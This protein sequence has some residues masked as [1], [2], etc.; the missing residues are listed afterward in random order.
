M[1]HHAPVKDS[2][3]AQSLKDADQRLLNMLAGLN[4]IGSAINRIGTEENNHIDSA[5]HLIAKTAVKVLP[6]ATALV[7]P[8]DQGRR[9]FIP[10]ALVAEVERGDPA[11]VDPTILDAMGNLAISQRRLILSYNEDDLAERVNPIACFPLIVA[12]QTLGT[13]SICLNIQRRFSQVEL[14]MLENFVY[15]AAMAFYQVR[16]VT[17]VQQDLARKEDEVSRLRRAGLLISSRLRIEETL[18]AILQM[19]LEVINAHYGIFRLVDKD[20]KNLVTRAVAEEHPARPLIETLPIDT[21]SVMGWVAIYRQA[22]MIS[23][24]QAEPWSHIYYPLD[25][26]L[27]MRSELAVPLIGANGR[28]E[29]V[30]NLESPVPEAFTEQDSHLLQALAT[31]AVIAIQ[32][33]RLLDA[34]QEVAQI[35]LYQPIQTVLDRLVELACDL[36]NASTSA[37]WILNGEELVLQSANQVSQHS[38]R[39]PLHNSLTGQAILERRPIIVDG[40]RDDPRFN[41]PDLAREQNWTR[42]LIVPLLDSDNPEPVGAFSVY[43]AGSDPGRFAESEWDKKVLTCL[44]YYAALAVHNA[45]RQEALRSAQE[46]RAVAETF[47]AVGDIAANLLHH[48]NNKVGTIP[49]RIQGIQDKCMPAVLAD[50]YLANNLKEIERSAAEAMETVRENLAH[51]RPIHLA[52]VA[53]SACIYAAVDSANLPAR[54]KI[55]L[56]ALDDLPVVMAGQTGLTLVFANLIENAVDAM[57]GEGVVTLTGTKGDGFVEVAVSDTGPGIPSDLH[58]RIFELNYSGRATTRPGKLGFGLWWVKTLMA[59]LGGS[60]WVESDGK[61]GTTFHLKLP[62]AEEKR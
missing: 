24:L 62:R 21:H 28:M 31:Q 11:L 17:I 38:Q 43:S 18:D 45:T 47:A 41:Q 50:P 49:V 1:K 7:Y 33:A 12:E 16:R 26:D 46:Q 39:I 5:L 59:R 3:A 19:A 56:E 36:L 61:Q 44:G 29:G 55:N 13:L 14:L 4:R 35:L 10:D 34:L 2:L 25:A 52:P 30:L 42:A 8:Y 27:E 51:L 60:V 58:D 40:L 23:D 22:V 37:I 15:Q 54:V 53:V 48:L 9:T 57:H 32:E 20:G 6:G